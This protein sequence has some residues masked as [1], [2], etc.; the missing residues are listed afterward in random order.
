MSLEYL[1]FLFEQAI[2][3]P[4]FKYF[5]TSKLPHCGHFSPPLGSAQS[6]NEQSGYF[7]QPQKNVPYLDFLL[8]SSPS[9]PAF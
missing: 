7:E 2:L 3:L 6:A 9:R 5:L 1:Q 4:L 8:T